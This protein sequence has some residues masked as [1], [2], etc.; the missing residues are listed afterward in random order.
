MNWVI[1]PWHTIHDTEENSQRH[2]GYEEPG[3]D[4]ADHTQTKQDESEVLE[5][6]LGLHGQT[7]VHCAREAKP[8][9]VKT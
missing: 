9:L 4:D 5:E 1:S 3:K 6:H 7:H 2:D 8:R